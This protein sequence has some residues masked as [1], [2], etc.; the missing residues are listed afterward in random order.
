MKKVN[1]GQKY[2]QVPQKIFVY[3]SII[4]SLQKLIKMPGFRSKC[5]EWRNRYVPDGWLA[6]VY[7]GQLWKDWMKPNSVPFL[8]VPGNL[9][10]MLNI[11]WFQPFEHRE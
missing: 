10:L 6:D 7:D 5:E 2:K 3:Y 11:D 8:E 9:A 1:I 4:E